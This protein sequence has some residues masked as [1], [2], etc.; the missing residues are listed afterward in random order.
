M[1]YN[2]G[3]GVKVIH[4]ELCKKLKF[5]QTKKWY[6][7]NPQSVLEN[8]I[9]KPFWDF[10]IQTGHLISDQ[11]TRP[12]NNQQEKEN[13]PNCELCCPDWPQSKIEKK[14]KRK[15]SILT[16]VPVV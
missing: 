10:K 2:S 1:Q 15:I 8:E 12:Y 9:H 6:L 11:T 16:G 14:A 7:Q 13:L 5:D 3:W 4:G